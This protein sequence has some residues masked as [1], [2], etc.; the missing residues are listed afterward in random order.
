[1]SIIY[2]KELTMNKV[3][4]TLTIVS[5]SF[6]ANASDSWEG[7]FDQGME[8]ERDSFGSSYTTTDGNFDYWSTNSPAHEIEMDRENQDTNIAS[9]SESKVVD[10][11]NK[12]HENKDAV[13]NFADSLYPSDG[14]AFDCAL[15]CAFCDPTFF[16]YSYSS[17]KQD[18]IFSF[19]DK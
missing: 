3:L 13:M 17:Q 6:V 10:V 9:Q 11:E 2:T 1:M 4:L 18:S 7:A 19:D 12:D 5:M 8:T 16:D 14:C 15:G